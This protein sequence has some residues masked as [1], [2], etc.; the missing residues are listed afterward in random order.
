M[1]EIV[2]DILMTLGS[3]GVSIRDRA[4]LKE[5]LE[6]PSK[7]DYVGKELY[8]AFPE[9]TLV[10]GCFKSA[11]ILQKITKELN[12]LKKFFPNFEYSVTVCGRT[13]EDYINEWKKYYTPIEIAGLAVIPVWLEYETPKKKILI[14]PGLA[15]GT[16]THETTRL[17][18]ELLQK[19]IKGGETVIDAGCG[20][21]ILGVAALKLGASKCYLIDI[22]SC[23]TD[24]ARANCLLNGYKEPEAVIITGDLL[25]GLDVCADIVIANITA[26]VLLRL[27]NCLKSRI[28]PGGVIILS[29]IL[30]VRLDDIK[31]FYEKE[32]YKLIGSAALGE[33]RALCYKYV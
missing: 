9:R 19:H 18:L 32:G 33:W 22:D 13:E 1:S 27:T 15:F 26:D 17:C 24:S 23:A 11:K 2:A 31:V 7:W 6:S 30:D 8:D 3:E 20:S 25:S 28:K 21:G 12:G 16:G 29:G 5:L 10:S 4:D 14:D